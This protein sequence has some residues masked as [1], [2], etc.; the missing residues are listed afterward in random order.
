VAIS[1]GG[2]SIMDPDVSDN[3]AGVRA[4]IFEVFKK[5]INKVIS[6]GGLWSDKLTGLEVGIDVYCINK[7]GPIDFK[8]VKNR[9]AD[10]TSTTIFRSHE[11][12]KYTTPISVAVEFWRDVH[13]VCIGKGFGNKVYDVY[14]GAGNDIVAINRSG[15]K[16][17]W[18]SSY[19]VDVFDVNMS[20]HAIDNEIDYND[21]DILYFDP[22]WE[23]VTD[24]NVFID[25]ELLNFQKGR[26]I[27]IF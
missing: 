19:V 17:G 10:E 23:E 22:P 4:I 7:L 18:N 13:S 6:L 25:N 2:R 12:E 11:K 16:V 8:P 3:A 24:W 9:R 14:P 27:F 1:T 21:S 26:R 20:Y 15:F 5:W